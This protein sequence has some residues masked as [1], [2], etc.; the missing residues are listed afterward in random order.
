MMRTAITFIY[1][2]IFVCLTSGSEPSCSK[3]HYEEKTLEKIIRQ[4]ILVEKM[5]MEIEDSK[6]EVKAAL[7]DLSEDRLFFENFK[8]IVDTFLESM[9]KKQEE[10]IED[11]K[12]EVKTLRDSGGPPV[13]A[14]DAH[15]VSDKAMSDGKTIVF[16]DI[17][18]NPGNGYDNIT[19]TFVAPVGGIY[20]FTTQICLDKIVRS[21]YG[22][23]VNEDVIS[24][25]LLGDAN[26]EKCYT[27]NA[28]TKLTEGDKVA[29]RCT[30][31]CQDDKLWENFLVSNSFS[32]SLVMVSK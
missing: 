32:G 20:L 11:F 8:Q 2:A 22:I 24:S 19:G 7:S 25:S 5:K 30:A 18:I 1:C 14:F 4:E 21:Y 29:V 31:Y 28:V 23:A 16:T 15:K 12:T 26:Y 27:I 10:S 9:R 6:Q 3:F 13:I 17:R